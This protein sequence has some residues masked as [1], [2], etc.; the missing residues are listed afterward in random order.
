MFDFDYESLDTFNRAALAAIV[1]VASD[2]Q[3]AAI[4]GHDAN[5]YGEEAARI[6]DAIAHAPI[7]TSMPE[8]TD[9]A[10]YLKVIGD[11]AAEYIGRAF[12]NLAPQVVD[13]AGNLYAYLNR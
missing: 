3:R 2:A 7:D 4:A 9:Y 5:S 6:R 12:P 1:P 8:G 10:Q 11:R 13:E